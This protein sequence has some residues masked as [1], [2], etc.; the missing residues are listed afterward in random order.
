M[1]KGV[2]EIEPI[3]AE[4]RPEFCSGCRICLNLCPYA[5]IGFDEER[6]VAE[7]NPLLCKGCGICV[8]ACPSE[9]VFVKHFTTE[10]ILAQIEG[11]LAWR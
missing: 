10:Q 3:T 6:G 9:A 11:A 8:A 7:V 2:V 5:A 4:V 1:N